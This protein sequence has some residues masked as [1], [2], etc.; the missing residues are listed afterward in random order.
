MQEVAKIIA[1]REIQRSI[2]VI[3]T[4]VPGRGVRA[5]AVS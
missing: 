3:D 5:Q 4:L 1:L 2:E